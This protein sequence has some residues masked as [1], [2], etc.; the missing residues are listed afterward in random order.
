VVD[1]PRWL[2]AVGLETTRR[3]DLTVLVVR[4]DLR[5]LAAARELVAWLPESSVQ[6]LLRGRRSATVG[7]E[8]VEES[9]GLPVL[10][11]V[12]DE[13]AVRL[14][15][16]RGEPPS[17]AARSAL[18]RACREVLGQLPRRAATT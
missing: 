14:A 15:A 5:G 13:A 18:A 7:S 1:L 10:A 11:T 17:T 3:A 8:L 6:V 4:A 2:S 9:L 16:E 12:A